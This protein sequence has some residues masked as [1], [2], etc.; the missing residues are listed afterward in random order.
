MTQFSP[1]YCRKA[2]KITW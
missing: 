1:T 2:F